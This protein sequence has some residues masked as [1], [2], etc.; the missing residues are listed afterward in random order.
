MKS[1]LP[2]ARTR[3]TP[4]RKLPVHPGASVRKTTATIPLFLLESPFAT[5]SGSY[6]SLLTAS[7]TFSRVAR[8]ILGSPFRARLTVALSTP[9]SLATWTI[10]TLMLHAPFVQPVAI[11]S[12]GKPPRTH[13]LQ[14][15][16]SLCRLEE[17]SCS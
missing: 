11:L 13:R 6:P 17:S 3:S 10:V 8:E 4:D 16:R 1:V 14:W 9:A 2:L 15:T 5:A 7:Q 12:P